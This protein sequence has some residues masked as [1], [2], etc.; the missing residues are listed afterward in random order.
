MKELILSRTAAADYISSHHLQETAPKKETEINGKKYTQ[1]SLEEKVSPLHRV[2]KLVIAVACTLVTLG[3]A[4]LTKTVRDLYSKALKGPAVVL[5]YSPTPALEAYMRVLGRKPGYIGT[6]DETTRWPEYWAHMT[7]ENGDPLPLDPTDFV[8][9]VQ[10]FDHLKPLPGGLERDIFL[11]YQLLRQVNSGETLNLLYKGEL[12][13]LEAKQLT[14]EGTEIFEESVKGM[15]ALFLQDERTG[16]ETISH[17]SRTQPNPLFFYTLNGGGSVLALDLSNPESIHPTKKDQQ[18]LQQLEGAHPSI[19]NCYAG[20]DEEGNFIIRADVPGAEQV[21][22]LVNSKFIVISH[23]CGFF[24]AKV[25]KV[26]WD[27]MTGLKN[28]TVT[29]IE[30]ALLSAQFSYQGGIVILVTRI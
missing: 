1:H 26:R 30:E 20:V 21:E 17:F 23:N 8:L 6:E 28:K 5:I 7:L 3:F 13:E 29:Q 19:Q 4:L 18:V 27:I 12:I 15:R 9:T 14:D 2:I 25:N 10:L 22:I 24:G 16:L 11:P